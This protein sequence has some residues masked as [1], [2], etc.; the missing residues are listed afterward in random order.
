[1]LTGIYALPFVAPDIITKGKVEEL[2]DI[3]IL[4]KKEKEDYDYI[5]EQKAIDNE[6]FNFYSRKFHFTKK[7]K[8]KLDDSFSEYKKD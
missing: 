8:V 2:V 3:I 4:S 1:Q 6:I 5:V 7:L